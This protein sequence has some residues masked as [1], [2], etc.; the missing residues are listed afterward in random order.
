MAGV[1][2][3][4]ESMSDRMD[5]AGCG[6]HGGAGGIELQGEACHQDERMAES[7]DDSTGWSREAFAAIRI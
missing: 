7:C 4:C 2:D 5:C 3:V 6:R 1:V